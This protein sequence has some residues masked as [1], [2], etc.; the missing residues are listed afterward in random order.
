MADSARRVGTARRAV[1][2]LAL[3]AT[4]AVASVAWAERETDGVNAGA[5]AKFT[6]ES[7]ED[8]KQPFETTCLWRAG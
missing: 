3:L 8:W 1:R 7:S 5:S 6:A 4:L 2:D